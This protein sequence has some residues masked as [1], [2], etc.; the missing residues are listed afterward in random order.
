MVVWRPGE[1]PQELSPAKVCVGEHCPHVRFELARVRPSIAI[2]KTRVFEH[3]LTQVDFNR[4]LLASRP[5]FLPFRPAREGRHHLHRRAVRMLPVT[6]VCAPLAIRV[7]GQPHA[8]LHLGVNLSKITIST[9]A[10]RAPSPHGL[11]AV[12]FVRC[13]LCIYHAGRYGIRKRMRAN[14]QTSD[15]TSPVTF[16]LIRG[17]SAD[18]LRSH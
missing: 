1:R 15:I 13:A 14:D 7:T 3:S 11:E 16:A 12:I 18:E 10:A 9:C 8:H 17:V 5:P 2:D 4:A 6:C